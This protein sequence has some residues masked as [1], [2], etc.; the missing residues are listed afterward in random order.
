MRGSTSQHA[1][2]FGLR[3]IPWTAAVGIKLDRAPDRNRFIFLEFLPVPP[4][5]RGNVDLPTESALADL[6]QRILAVAVRH[7]LAADRMAT[8]LRNTQIE[9]VHGRIVESYSTPTALIATAIGLSREQATEA[10]K[11]LVA[12]TEQDPGSSTKD[13]TELLGEILASCIQLD[14]G[15]QAV[16]S[17]ILTNGEAYPGGWDAIERYGLTVIGEKPG[18]QPAQFE[19]QRG[20]LFVA[21]RAVQRRLLRDTRWADQPIDQILLRLPGAR[22]GQHRVAGQRPRGVDVPWRLLSE[23]YLIPDDGES[24]SSDEGFLLT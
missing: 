18:D 22:R 23:R 8:E 12:R 10:I 20:W 17:Q 2:H 5:R 4:E 6:G 19:S 21:T 24:T 16:V 3:H 15:M 9:G 13:Q 11:N 1:Q 14:R 7:V